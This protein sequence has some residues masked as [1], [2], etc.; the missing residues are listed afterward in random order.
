MFHVK[1]ATIN[2]VC[3]NFAAFEY[4]LYADDLRISDYADVCVWK[5]MPSFTAYPSI[6][7]LYLH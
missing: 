4:T 3:E 6:F 5:L 7:A 2:L 1:T